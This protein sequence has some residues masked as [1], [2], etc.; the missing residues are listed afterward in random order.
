MVLR[1][2]RNT[3]IG[4]QVCFD[5]FRVDNTFTDDTNYGIRYDAWSGNWNGK[6]LG[7]GYRSSATADSSVT[8]TIRGSSFQWITNRGPNQ[9][10]ADVYVDDKFIVTVDLYFPT[11]KWQ[12]AILINKLGQGNHTVKIVVLGQHNSASGGNTIVFDGILVP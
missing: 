11:Q 9:G 12:Q 5:G 6:A 7:G 1:E 2:K 4:Y 10:Q 8:F 3:S